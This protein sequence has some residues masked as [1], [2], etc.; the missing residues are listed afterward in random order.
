MG[1]QTTDLHREEIVAQVRQ[2]T[3]AELEGL[4]I[5]ALLLTAESAGHLHRAGFRTLGEMRQPTPT[6]LAK[7]VKIPTQNRWEI[8]QRW[9]WVVRCWRHYFLQEKARALE[10][11]ALPESAAQITAKTDLLSSVEDVTD[12]VSDN[13]GLLEFTP[14]LSLLQSQEADLR[15]QL[16]DIQFIGELAISEMAF[17]GMCRLVQTEAVSSTGKPAPQ[18]VPSALFVTLMVFTARFASVERRNFWM[19]YCE[20]VWGLPA[21]EQQFQD[22]CRERFAAAVRELEGLFPNLLPFRQMSDGDVARPIY[23]HAVLP[24]YLEEDFTGWLQN[25]WPNILD[26]PV[27]NLAEALQNDRRVANQPRPLALFLQGEETS[28]TAVAL[29]TQLAEGIRRTLAGEAVTAVSEQWPPHTILRAIWQAIS[30]RLGDTA[31]A[32][33]SF[34]M[35]RGKLEWVWGLAENELFL[36]LRNLTLKQE[37]ERLVWEA[38]DTTVFL[39]PWQLEGGYWWLDELSLEPSAAIGGSLIILDSAGQELACLEAPPLPEQDWLLFRIDGLGTGAETAVL[40]TDVRAS[41]WYCLSAAADVTLKGEI[42]AHDADLPPPSLLQTELNHQQ[43]GLCYLNLPVTVWQGGTQIAELIA[44]EEEAEQPAYLQGRVIAGTSPQMPPVYKDTAVRFVIPQYLPGSVLWLRCGDEN[45]QIPLPEAA[46]SGELAVDLAPYLQPAPA[47]YRLELRHGLGSLLK[48]PLEFVVIPGIQISPPSPK[49]LYHPGM[50]PTCILRGLTSENILPNSRYQY[51]VHPDGSLY[52]TWLDWREDDCRL[53]LQFGEHVIQLGWPL[54]QRIFSWVEPTPRHGFLREQDLADAVIQIIAPNENKLQTGRSYKYILV[55]IEGA[56]GKSRKIEFSKRGHLSRIAIRAG[57]QLHEMIHDYIREHPGQMARVRVKLWKD[58]W[59]LL[60]VR[61]QPQIAQA[62]ASYEPNERVVRFSCDIAVPWKGDIRFA[63]YDLHDPFAPPQTW[64]F[65]QLERE[66][67]LPMNDT[68]VTYDYLLSITFD[69]QRLKL[70]QPLRLSRGPKAAY[71]TADIDT[72]FDLLQER[73]SGL[74]PPQCSADFVRLLARQVSSAQVVQLSRKRL[75]QL[76]TIPNPGE[77]SD[78][79]EDLDRL[80]VGLNRLRLAH[81]SAAWF[82]QHGLLP[83]WAVLDRPLKLQLQQHPKVVLTLVAE[84]ALQKGKQGV[85]YAQL[86]LDGNDKEK[87]YVSWKPYRDHYVQALVG[88]VGDDQ[89]LYA[90]VDEGDLRPIRQCSFCGFF[91]KD[92]QLPYTQRR[93]QSCLKYYQAK[94]EPVT[95]TGDLLA[96]LKLEDS[97][98]SHAYRPQLYLDQSFTIALWRQS[99][100]SAA[101]TS[102][103]PID[104]AAYQYAAAQWVGRYRCDSQQ[105]ELFERIV[106]YRRRSFERLAE[107]LPE[108]NLP[109]FQAAARFLDVFQLTEPCLY[110][111]RITLLLALLLR[112]R[113]HNPDSMPRLLRDANLTV[114]NLERLLAMTDEF[115]PEL[116]LWAFTWIE[117]FFAHAVD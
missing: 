32:A 5:Q 115:C 63:L 82:E 40:Q 19:P 79:P 8:M 70:P 52:L 101:P 104:K 9:Q 60:E 33:A 10:M 16:L 3:W 96:T 67:T 34:R 68:A 106:N 53:S 17:R 57:D 102:A 105:Q 11:L 23:R 37:P 95:Y 58:E 100:T 87:V 93:H 45:R 108:Y 56:E 26:I 15:L 6:Q 107:S 24:A 109:A 30:G 64:H 89:E 92:S 27:A 36:R 46:L 117:L 41:D 74:V 98:V 55:W 111:D 116:L 110:L 62:S 2:R 39:N 78:S 44:D 25:E 35:G 69:S 47:A 103:N 7:A 77:F 84:K 112:T 43:A 54:P 18:T 38:A 97:L 114:S 59:Q 50:P 20:M 73:E 31:A 86:K 75:Y 94:F 65:G 12:S 1:Q 21:V 80:W 83:S 85:G 61:P 4:T 28:E 71:K 99:E 66:H 22:E 113:A 51:T 72:L 13:E 81:D 14:N 90:E 76:A 49:H 29:I 48:K 88:W 91:L 42:T